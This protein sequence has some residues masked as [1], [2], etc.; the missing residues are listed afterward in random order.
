MWQGFI[1]ATVPSESSVDKKVGWIIFLTSKRTWGNVEKPE[2]M[3]DTAATQHK[4][5]TWVDG[6]IKHKL[7]NVDQV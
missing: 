1:H 3:H 7:I 6:I 4:Q 5:S 2:Q